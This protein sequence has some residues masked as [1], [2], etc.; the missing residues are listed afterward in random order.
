MRTLNDRLASY[1][2]KV[3]SLEEENAHLEKKIREWY[4]RNRPQMLPDFNG[5]FGEIEDLQRKIFTFTMENTRLSRQVDNTRL[6][7]DDFQHKYELEV[8]LRTNVEQDVKALRLELEAINDEAEDLDVHHQTLQQDLLKK[9][10]TNQD[11]INSLYNQ[12][13][14]RVTVEV[15]T[16]Q[17]VNLSNLLSEIREQYEELMENNKSEAEKWFLAKV[18]AIL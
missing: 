18:C 6:A 12:L 10:K 15:D 13:G 7:V 8:K 14:A 3:R 2:E 5:F 4:D 1:L 16:P 11:A 9:K 17:T